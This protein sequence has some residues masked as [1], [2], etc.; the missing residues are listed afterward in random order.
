MTVK[1]VSQV[2]YDKVAIYKFK[3][4]EFEDI[5]NGSFNDIPF[6]IL[7]MEVKLIGAKRKN[8]IDI[9]I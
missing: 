1:D 2:S 5:Y 4:D 3:D 9:R 6:E 7:N 8:I